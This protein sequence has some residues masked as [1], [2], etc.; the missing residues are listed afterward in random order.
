[1]EYA[2]LIYHDETRFP[3]LPPAEREE[4]LAA[5]RAYTESLR[6][7]GEFRGS[8]KLGGTAAATSVRVRDGRTLNTDGPFAETKEQLAGL[9]VVECES[10]DD[11]LER[12]AALPAARFG[13]VEVRPIEFRG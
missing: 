9:Y 4:W 8:V 1:M 5:Y 6:R 3:R 12:A 2:L 10:L 7:A 11:A 13:T